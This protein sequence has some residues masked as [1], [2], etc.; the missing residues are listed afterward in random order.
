M[1]KPPSTTIFSP[2]I[3]F[4]LLVDKN[5]TILLTSSTFPILLTTDLFFRMLFLSVPFL[6]CF[7]IKSVD[8]CPGD[9]LFTDIL[10]FAHSEATDLVNDSIPALLTE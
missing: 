9:I 8:I 4:E 5:S 6:I 3:K 2:V 10:Y 7:S 1:L